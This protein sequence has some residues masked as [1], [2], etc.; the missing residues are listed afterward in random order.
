MSEFPRSQLPK[1]VAFSSKVDVLKRL[2][3]S[4][5]LS[6]EY[7][8]SCKEEIVFI[9]SVEKKHYSLQTGHLRRSI[10]NKAVTITGVPKAFISFP[11]PF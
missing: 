6:D 5:L 1:D 10:V 7:R 9:K 2:S 4:P 11:G 3:E 8:E